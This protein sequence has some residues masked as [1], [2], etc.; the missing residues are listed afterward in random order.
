MSIHLCPDCLHMNDKTQCRTCGG[1]CYVHRN[2]FGRITHPAD[3][4]DFLRQER[5]KGYRTSHGRR[6]PTRFPR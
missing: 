2:S 5:E 6:M 4:A 3:P 1:S